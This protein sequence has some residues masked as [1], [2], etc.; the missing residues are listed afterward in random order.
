M[1]TT[2]GSVHNSTPPHTQAYS[3]S[4]PLSVY[5]E[6]AAELQA[7]QTKLDAL[8][9]QNQ[10]LV[11][12]NHLLRQEIAKAI[13]SVL[14]LQK[15]VDSQAKV[16]FHQTSQSSGDY[17]TETKRPVTETS[18]KE[19]VSHPRTSYARPNIPRGKPSAGGLREATQVSTSTPVFL[20]EME[21]PSSIPDPVFIEE[22][23]VS[24]YPDS[25]SEPSQIRGWWLIIA[26]LLIIVL[27]FGAGYLVVRPLFEH[28][29]R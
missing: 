10:Q 17:R 18:P 26:I 28:Q 25:Q 6:L 19:Q 11:Q 12:E 2:S 5:G 3:P 13:E 4:V 16:S 29:N 23:E 1:R 15:L 9:G 8:N 22:Q 24:Y 7:V 20:P 27:G 21:I 14:R